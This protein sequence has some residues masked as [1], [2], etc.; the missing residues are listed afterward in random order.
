M[1]DLKLQDLR[2]KLITNAALSDYTSFRVG[3]PASLLFLPR[4]IA[5][6]SAF[7]KQ[8]P[9]KYALTWLGLGSNVLI[10]DGGVEG[11]VIVT[12]G[13]LNTISQLEMTTIRA[14]AGVSCAQIA[15]YTARLGLTGLEF[16][17]GIPGTVGGAL[18][19]NAGCYGGE[20]WKRVKEVEVIDRNGIV[21][22]RQAKDYAI[23][24]REVKRPAE[25]WFLAGHFVLDAGEKNRSLQDIRWLLEKRNAAQPT[26]LP[27]CGSVFRNPPGLHA[28][29]LIE[30]CGMKGLKIGGAKISEK[31][32][33]FIIN[34]GNAKASDIEILIAHIMDNVF[35]QHGVRLMPEVCIIGKAASK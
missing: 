7:L 18:A 6:V 5:D 10:R 13:A 17:A 12:Q 35:K 25:E 19:M 22:T 31:H 26:G 21:K 23:G 28:A 20:T 3:G 30:L 32:A 1:H 2:G 14:E 34:E 4:D 27:N 29:K 8:L 11:A 33:N 9:I 15:R 16:M 24:Y